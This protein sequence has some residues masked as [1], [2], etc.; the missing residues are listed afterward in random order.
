MVHSRDVLCK[1]CNK[2]LAHW[3]MF[4]NLQWEDEYECLGTF[5]KTLH[6]VWRSKDGKHSIRTNSPPVDYVQQ[7]T[8]TNFCAL[9][10]HTKYC[11]KCITRLHFKCVRPR[12]KGPVRL[13]RRKDGTTTKYAHGG[14]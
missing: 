2:V 12:C 3:D 8:E 6:D 4:S 11:K 5:R 13:V 14:Y 9:Y 10:Y 7:K 1:V